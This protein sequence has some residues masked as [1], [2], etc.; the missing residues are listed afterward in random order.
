MSRECAQRLKLEIVIIFKRK[1]IF[2]CVLFFAFIII[3]FS[4]LS[5]TQV[6][7]LSNNNDNCEV[8]ASLLDFNLI[9]TGDWD[10]TDITTHIVDNI[11]AKDPELVIGLGDYSYEPPADG[12]FEKIAP[13]EDRL[14]I[15]IGKS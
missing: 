3:G 12:W 14:K 13:L 2:D 15:S 4:L 1:D 9:A 5:I 11:S 8:Y 10:C 7:L 6:L